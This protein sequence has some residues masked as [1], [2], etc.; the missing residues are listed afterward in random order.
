MH[1]RYFE[2][3][4]LI[5]YYFFSQLF[6]FLFQIM[7]PFL[8][9]HTLFPYPQLLRMRKTKEYLLYGSGLFHLI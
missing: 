4:H 8:V 1:I 3:I 7:D 6:P 2:H 5:Y 9:P